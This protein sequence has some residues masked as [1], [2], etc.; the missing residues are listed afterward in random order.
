MTFCE[1]LI[2]NIFIVFNFFVAITGLV[3]VAIGTYAQVYDK[4]YINFLGNQYA[5]IPIF[6]IVVGVVIFVIAF[7]GCCGASRKS[8]CMLRTYA[9]F[10]IVICIVE[11]VAGIT[12][13][14]HKGVLK[15]ELAKNM[16]EGINNYNATYFEGVTQT[17]DLLQ[18][19]LQCCGVDG[20][21]DWV[22]ST[23][24]K[25]Q[26]RNIPAIVRHY[27]GLSVGSLEYGVGYV[28]R[29]AERLED[30]LRL[31][32][33][34][35]LGESLGVIFERR[36][37]K[38]PDSCCPRG[39]MGCRDWRKFKKGCL[40]SIEHLLRTN[41]AVVGGIAI[42]VCALQIFGLIFSCIIRTNSGENLFV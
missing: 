12:I 13:Y 26:A 19:E 17:W 11:I 16:K 32:L 36:P 27:L 35:S 1:S 9:A 42:G 4:N 31:D 8:R 7:Y 3:L 39:V 6:I 18:H 2:T 20:Q 15:D 5:S 38:I 23:V 34:L 10:L 41:I 14:V 37:G 30:S 28:D 29:M 40:S 33:G 22:V 24:G 21:E 25:I